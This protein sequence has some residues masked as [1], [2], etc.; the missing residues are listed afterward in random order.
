MII[1]NFANIICL[2][3]IFA[4]NNVKYSYMLKHPIYWNYI[5]K[6]ASAIAKKRKKGNMRVTSPFVE[7]SNPALGTKPSFT[8]KVIHL[9][10][11]LGFWRDVGRYMVS[12]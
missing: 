7:C 4:V 2:D 10:L 12:D 5:Q 8:E 6:Y 1:Y 11:I 3:T 9:T